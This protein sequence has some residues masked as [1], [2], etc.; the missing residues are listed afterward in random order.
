MVQINLYID[1]TENILIS[2]LNTS[3]SFDPN[4]IPFYYGD[5]VNLRV[6]LMDKLQVRFPSDFPYSI[7]PTTGLQLFLYL[8]DGTV[9]GTIYTQQ[10]SWATDANSQYFYATLAL[11][12]AALATLLGVSTGKTC[13]L[14]IG[15]VQ[16][17]LQTTVFSQ[18]INIG[19]GIPASGLVVPPGL[20]PLSVEVANATY[21]PLAPAAG[22]PLYI[23]SPNGKILI[24]RAVDQPDGTADM[25]ASPIN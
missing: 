8:D 9:G 1:T 19:V 20:T 21:Y 15:Y 13:Y 18:T 14:K 11:N 24:I 6:Y 2:G 5:T 25:E 7:I 3:G 22:V 17:G 10:I 4:K 16:A 12:T 23:T